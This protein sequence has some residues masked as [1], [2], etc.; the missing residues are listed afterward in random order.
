MQSP[1]PWLDSCVL[2]MSSRVLPQLPMPGDL[3]IFPLCSSINDF[4]DA[5]MGNLAEQCNVREVYLDSVSGLSSSFQW[6]CHGSGSGPAGRSGSRQILASIRGQVTSFKGLCLVT[7]HQS[8]PIQQ[9]PKTVLVTTGQHLSSELMRHIP[10]SI[11]S[12]VFI[13]LCLSCSFVYSM[14]V[15]FRLSTVFIYITIQV[16]DTSNLPEFVLHIYFFS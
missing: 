6:W 14:S 16:L 12:R 4:C 5:L 8:G 2:C 9:P 15:I 7:F 13:V 1:G 11:S 3:P 10:D